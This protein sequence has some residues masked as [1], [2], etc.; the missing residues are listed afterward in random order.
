[1]CYRDKLEPENNGIIKKPEVMAVVRII[2]AI[3]IGYALL[4]DDLFYAPYAFYA[5]G[6]GLLCTALFYYSVSKFWPLVHTHYYYRHLFWFTIG[7]IASFTTAAFRLVIP[8]GFV[9]TGFIVFHWSIFYGLAGAVAGFGIAQ[10]EYPRIVNFAGLMGIIVGTI[11]YIA[12]SE[13]F[14]ASFIVSQFTFGLIQFMA[15]L[16]FALIS[17]CVS[18]CIR[19]LILA[20]AIK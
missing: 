19:K 16:V 5:V 8:Y 1:V 3:I 12:L 2:K 14:Y 9:I 10:Y 6:G 17:L 11:Y 13:S 15:P 7:F 20:D 4:L 18:D